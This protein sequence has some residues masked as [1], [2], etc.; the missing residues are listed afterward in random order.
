MLR[1]A[2]RR[3]AQSRVRAAMDLRGRS[4][5]SSVTA[6]T[7]GVTHSVDAR[8]IQN[9]AASVAHATDSAIESFALLQRRAIL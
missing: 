3:L 6:R 1:K 5:P 7:H 2:G 4:C 9:R 8:S